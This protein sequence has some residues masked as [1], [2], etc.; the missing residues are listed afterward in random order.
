[1][2]KE[3][4]YNG[5]SCTEEKCIVVMAVVLEGRNMGFVMV[6]VIVIVVVVFVVI[7][8]EHAALPVK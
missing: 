5:D 4:C 7:V 8:V 1:M 6:V 2:R 3:I